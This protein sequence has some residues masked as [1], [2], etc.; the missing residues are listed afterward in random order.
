MTEDVLGIPILE[1]Y[2]KLGLLLFFGALLL[3]CLLHTY[4]P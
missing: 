2:Q 3:P 1:K 4:T